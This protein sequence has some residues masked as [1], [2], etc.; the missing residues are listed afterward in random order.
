[1][2]YQ[3][4]IGVLLIIDRC[5]IVISCNGRE[6]GKRN[7][8]V[9]MGGWEDEKELGEGKGEVRKGGEGIR[10]KRREREGKKGQRN[11]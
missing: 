10:G 4:R 9:E 7:R 5:T 1:M 8:W 11:I 6:N 3:L 2:S